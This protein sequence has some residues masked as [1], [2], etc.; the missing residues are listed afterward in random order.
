MVLLE[1]IIESIAIIIIGVLGLYS[2]AW[3]HEGTHYK[4]GRKYGGDTEIDYWFYGLPGGDIQHFRRNERQTNSH[5]WRTRG[6][7]DNTFP[8]C[9]L[10]DQVA[11]YAFRELPFL[12]IFC[13]FMDL[14]L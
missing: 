5:G 2:G 8:N 6:H 11:Y 7:L 14:T 13:V 10:S 1:L 12:Y 4:L 3:L 9:I